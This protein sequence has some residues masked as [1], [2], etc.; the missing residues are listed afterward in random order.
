MSVDKEALLALAN[1][2]GSGVSECY[3]RT[4]ISRAYY[5]AYHGC[6]T[7]HKALPMPGTDTGPAGGRHQQLLNRL[8]NPAPEVKD[9]VERSTSKI[10]SSQL[11]ALR[12]YR[13]TADYM[14]GETVDQALQATSYALAQKIFEKL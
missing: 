8:Y 11:G 13:V 4:S 9:P 5:A 1:E 12:G 6:D 7:W 2:L 3:L 10:L 14:L